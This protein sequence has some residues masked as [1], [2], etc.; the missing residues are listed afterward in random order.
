[1]SGG[2]TS[3]RALLLSLGVGLVLVTLAAFGTVRHC[4]FVSYDD[5]DY[6]TENLRIQA[7]LTL[8]GI[9]WAFTSFHAGNWH[10]VTWLSHMFDCHWFG[11]NPAAHHLINALLHTINA[12][13]L[14]IILKQY[15]G[16]VWRSVMVAALF[17]WH[18]LRVESVAWVSERKD[19]LSGL[20]FLLTLW[21][22]GCYAGRRN[23]L[24]E[25]RKVR[26]PQ[27]RHVPVPV[28]GFPF[29]GH[30]WLALAFYALGLMSKPMLVTL[31]FVL[32]LLDYWPLNRLKCEPSRLASSTGQSAGIWPFLLEKLP[33][34]VL[35]LISCG[36]TVW[37]QHAGGSVV[38]ME[39]LPLGHRIGNAA[40]SCWRYLWKTLW[41][42]DLAV[43]Y[44]YNHGV[45]QW[46]TL[47]AVAGL[48]ALTAVA[49]RAW[50]RPYVAVGWLWFLGMLLPVIGLVQV[51][52][53]AMAD[54]Y[55][56]LPS[57][58]LFVVAAF[59]L[60][61]LATR[62]RHGSPIVV[63]FVGFVLAACLVGVHRQ[64]A[65]WRNSETLFRRALAVTEKNY[66][67]CNNLG[68]VLE[69]QGRRLDAIELYHQALRFNPNC[70]EAYNNLGQ[71]L[72]ALG[73]LEE[74]EYHL[75]EAMTRDPRSPGTHYNFGN[76]RLRQGDP[77]AAVQAYR[78]ALALNGNFPDAHNVLGCLLA[79]RGQPDEAIVHFQHALRLRPDSAE[80]LG[81]LGNVLTEK[82]RAAE[83]L[84]LLSKVVSLKPNQAEAHY[85]LG[86][87]YL[88]LE[89]RQEAL[90]TYQTVV[91][92]KP[93]HAWAH[94]RLGNL[95]LADRNPDA[96]VAHYRAA[97]AAN[98]NHAEAHYQLATLLVARKDVEEGIHHYGEA[99]RLK[100]AWRE[101]LN[102]LAWLLATCPAARYR[103]GERAVELATKAVEVTRG[104]D[105]DT[106]DTLAAAYAEAGQF[107]KADAVAQQ[108]IERAEATGRGDLVSQLRD[109]LKRYRS[110]QPYREATP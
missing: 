34:F 87:A 110:Q 73:R 32:L 27:C 96:A 22:Y 1:M 20:F 76:L 44:P 45:Y 88:A 91:T 102:N 41:P 48:L 49:I 55:T 101:A 35:A 99:V 85:N 56:Y 79:A 90:V 83:A 77:Q 46:W 47:V 97:L 54:R 104:S 74:A 89:R 13:L 5:P 7:G 82:N 106:L 72:L 40:I 75:R 18:P 29:S 86:N 81:N 98:A 3:D 21:A 58:G 25:D 12:L 24:P 19:V 61:D 16:A 107:T 68:T 2:K 6:V 26:S 64:A 28:L 52:L 11:L 15:T 65:Y 67:A 8:R 84:P 23:L 30:Y 14:L 66:V 62:I 42:V 105:A 100:P 94:Y 92:L 109:R 80:A 53:Q 31:P 60:A 70:A 103:D 95:L 9:E 108:A 50:K 4:E 51:G 37:A 69:N 78:Q 39:A 71:S 63:V 43:L 57:I 36:L 17:A 33:F 59:G 38:S 93:E 10:P